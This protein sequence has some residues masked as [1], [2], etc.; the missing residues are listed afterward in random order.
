MK[1]CRP[2]FILSLL[3]VAL[4]ALWLARD[5]WRARQFIPQINSASRQAGV[6]PLLV[7]AVVWRESR[8]HPEARGSHGEIGLM[9]IQEIAAQQW[10]DARHNSDF[11][12]EHCLDPSTNTLAGAYYL[13]R[14]IKR[15]AAGDN[16]VPYALADYNAGRGNVLK[17]KT[18]EASTNSLAFIDHIGFRSTQ[19]YV[20]SVM[21]RHALY[22]WLGRLGWS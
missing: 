7:R 13:G 19:S 3:G 5:E 17:W 1:R 11:Q 4:T 16:P 6:D 9:Q 12:H 22:R 21:R 2:I 14:L 18:G 8:F 15:Y 10:A 20:K